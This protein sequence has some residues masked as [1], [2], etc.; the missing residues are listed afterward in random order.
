MAQ[1]VNIKTLR[2]MVRQKGE[3]NLSFWSV[4]TGEITHAQKVILTS[5][6]FNPE[7]ITVK[8][9][10]SKEVRTIHLVSIFAINDMEVIL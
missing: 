10:T 3:M 7:T 9:T 4:K 6:R 5:T 8:F 2:E 1:F